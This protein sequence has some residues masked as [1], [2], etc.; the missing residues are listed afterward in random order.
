[1]DIGLQILDKA[2][3]VLAF[4]FFKLETSTAKSSFGNLSECCCG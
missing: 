2:Q 4:D 1:M 3:L